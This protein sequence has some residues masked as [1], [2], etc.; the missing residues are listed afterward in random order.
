M[1]AQRRR[2]FAKRLDDERARLV[3]TV[4]ALETE[5]Q[6]DVI[7]A[8]P[9]RDGSSGA[10]SDAETAEAAAS[11][12]LAQLREVDAAITRLH[13]EPDRFGRCVV[14]GRQIGTRRLEL[15]P[16]A[17][18]CVEHAAAPRRGAQS[19]GREGAPILE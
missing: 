3:T 13:D 18:H 5:A 15:V 19:L 8:A 9:E 14:C 7:E 1:N 16:W 2:R 11:V 6:L 12:E 10:L 17:Q 4:R